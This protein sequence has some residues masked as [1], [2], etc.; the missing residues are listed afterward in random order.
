L[1]GESL[2]KA[3]DKGAFVRKLLGMQSPVEVRF[4]RFSRGRRADD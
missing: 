2:M 1:V 4:C 3:K